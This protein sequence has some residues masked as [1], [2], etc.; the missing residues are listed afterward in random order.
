MKKIIIAA[1]LIAGCAALSWGAPGDKTVIGPFNGFGT[2][3][4][5]T[6]KVKATKP[7]QTVAFGTGSAVSGGVVNF[8]AGGGG[9]WGSITGTL[10]AQTDLQATLDAKKGTAAFT[11]YSTNRQAE[12]NGKLASTAQAADSAK[13]GGTAAVTV[14]SGAAAGATAL[15]PSGSQASTTGIG[16]DVSTALAGKQATGNYITALT[17]DVTASGPGSSA[18]T[19]A[20]IRNVNVDA[21][22]MATGDYLNFDGTNI[23]HTPLTATILNT[24]YGYT[25]AAALGF[26]PLDRAGS[27]TMLATLQ[28]A[29][30]TFAGN[31]ISGGNANYASTTHAT[32]GTHIFDSQ[33]LIPNGISGVP[34]IGFVGATTSGYS[35]RGGQLEMLVS[36]SI[37]ISADATNINFNKQIVIATAGTGITI[38]TGTNACMGTG[39]L[40]S[41][42]V[43]V[44][45]SC[46]KTGSVIFLTDTSAGIV[47][48]GSLTNSA[49]V[50][51]VS[52]DVKSTNVADTSTFNWIIFQPL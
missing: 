33:L 17:G 25:P 7:N 29:G 38:K 1:L 18:A 42:A 41:G 40:S 6:G 11:T 32:K 21:T 44:N 47:N 22:S 37:V 12:I 4:T 20:K 48:L 27:N 14:V 51:G 35:R 52:F 30:N 46:A 8:S 49:I 3:S 26:T 31:S 50:N 2:I 28:M 19:V 5:A 43:T 23:V 36:G 10:S 45:T 24:V 16:G 15:Q 34:A 39:T 9:T 13:L